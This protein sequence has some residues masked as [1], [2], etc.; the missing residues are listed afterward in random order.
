M[1]VFSYIK[2]G[3]SL[4]QD[5]ANCFSDHKALKLSASLAYYTI[6]SLAPMLIVIIALC[7]VFFGREAIE[8]QIYQQL[9][10]FIGNT[11]ALQIQEI[12]KNTS[13]SGNTFVATVFG[14]V[15]LIIGATGVFTEIQD[16]INIVW[17][18]RV[19]PK[20]GWLKLLVN[21][22]ISFSMI[23]SIGFLLMVSLLISSLISAF[24]EKLSVYFP[25][26]TI[27][28]FQVIDFLIT[29][30]VI[31]L[32]FAI[33]FK[34]LPDA[35]IK[36]RDVFVG[37]VFT[38][39]LF[40]IGKL[41]ITFYLGRSNLGLAYG[42]AGSVIVILVWVYYS[43]II[44]YFGAEFTQVY[45]RK[46]GGEIQPTTYATLISSRK[47]KKILNDE[48]RGEILIGEN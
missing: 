9:N 44:L 20:R 39:T 29:Y 43:S 31:T 45:A 37:S 21:R 12:I 5:S 47:T 48:E 26:L 13:L 24:S 23:V 35:K 6:F 16:S 11:A 33:I 22:V 34:V 30:S 42:A 18:I 14:T 46:H 40:I 41:G 7:S 27:Y 3:W 17:G 10:E 36:W 8:G 25:E 19:R 28:V 1:K 38:A 4:L 15:A 2:A 32:L